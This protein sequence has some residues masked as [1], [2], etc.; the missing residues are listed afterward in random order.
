MSAGGAM[1]D[2]AVSDEYRA[3]VEGLAV[4]DRGGRARWRV[5]GRAPRQM[6]NGILTGTIPATPTDAPD[7]MRGGL[8][9]YHAV[10]TPKGKMISDAW[11]FLT[12][13]EE[14][15]GFLLDVPE[16]GEPPLREHLGKVLP[17]R[18]AKLD[19]VS[20]ATGMI[21]VTGPEAAAA[22]SRI[23]FGLRI[24]VEALSRLEEG[25]WLMAGSSPGGLVVMRTRE[26]TPDAYWVIGDRAAV[27]AL[28]DRLVEAGAMAAGTETWN[29][30]R[31]E[32]GRP[33][34]G[35]DMTDERLP[36]EAGIHDRVIDH[37]KGC[38]TGQEVIVRIR[39]RG[40]VN[41][42]L[43]RLVLGDVPVP[44]AGTELFAPGD[45][46]KSVGWITSAVRS[47]AEGGIVALAYV[48]RGVDQVVF[49]GREVAVG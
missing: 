21:A 11:V 38:Y 40:H 42:H 25:G 8:A 31:V 6:L 17:P 13:D 12:G 33:E 30:L 36:I 14:A 18:L 19:D 1:V 47:P 27:R 22:L 23:A 26:V 15:D 2:G 24:E 49:A 29:T 41:R 39:D 44:E 34:F 48:R 9:S 35:V 20:D 10:L 46:A 43:R 45:D 28:R 5:S 16:A 32:A 3:A 7:G 4:F 37:Q